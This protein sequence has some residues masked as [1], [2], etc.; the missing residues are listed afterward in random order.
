MQLAIE[1]PEDIAAELRA[2]WKD[3]SRH[4]LEAIALEGYRSGELTQWQVQRLLGFDNRVEAHRFLQ[5][6]EAYLE[7]TRA[8]VEREIETSRRLKEL[9]DA[10]LHP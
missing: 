1:V 7:Y 4:A 3:L 6:H 9:H 2:K 5:Q 8:E 10:E